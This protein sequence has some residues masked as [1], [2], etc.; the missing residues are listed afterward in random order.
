MVNDDVYKLYDLTSAGADLKEYVAYDLGARAGYHDPVAVFTL[1][2][3][4]EDTGVFEDVTAT[5]IADTTKFTA[6][7]LDD[8]QYDALYIGSNFKPTGARINI[9]VAGVD[10]GTL[11]ATWEYPSASDDNDMP[12][13]WAD[14]NEEDNTA[15]ASG[16]ALDA[17]TST[18][19]V[20]FEVP[21]DWKKT[22]ISTVDSTLKKQQ[23]KMYWFKLMVGT[24]GYSTAPTIERIQL[25]KPIKSEKLKVVTASSTANLYMN[26]TNTAGSESEQDAYPILAT[27]IYEIELGVHNFTVKDLGNTETIEIYAKGYAGVWD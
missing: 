4:A 16:K 10:A 15:S 24:A 11:V 17:G 12:S 2:A 27:T 22:L 1:N 7:P 5:A 13:T 19:T 26:T 21:T 25:V 8:A 20:E 9:G 18:Y 14:L 3:T 23:Y 6:I